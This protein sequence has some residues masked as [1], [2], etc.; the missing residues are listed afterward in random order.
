[1]WSSASNGKSIVTGPAYDVHVFSKVN[2]DARVKSEHREGDKDL[3]NEKMPSQFSRNESAEAEHGP[4]CSEEGITEN[5]AQVN[6][7]TVVIH[8]PN[9]NGMEMDEYASTIFK[10]NN[11]LNDEP[12]DQGPS[13]E[14]ME[15]VADDN[16]ASEYANIGDEVTGVYYQSVQTNV[17]DSEYAYVDPDQGNH[18]GQRILDGSGGSGPHLQSNI[19]PVDF[20]RAP[21]PGEYAALAGPRDETGSHY[22]SLFTGIGSV[23]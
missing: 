1:M 12:L 13:H 5:R 17:F 11:Q 19:L 23:H 6:P 22:Q 3:S 20:V 8:Q 7:T 18:A 4:S 14:Y 10:G 16:E 15:C 9:K 21:A 2:E